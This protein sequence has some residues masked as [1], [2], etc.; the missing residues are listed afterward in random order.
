[1]C[2]NQMT[3]KITS[4]NKE[5]IVM[6]VIRI[7]INLRRKLKMIAAYENLSMNDKA[8]YY[9]EKGIKREEKIRLG[10]LQ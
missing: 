1:M 10:A 2:L 5:D 4:K 9:I 8:K 6:I 3:K 7:S